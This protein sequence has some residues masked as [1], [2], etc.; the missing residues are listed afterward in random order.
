M[1]NVLNKSIQDQT[2]SNHNYIINGSF[3]VNQRNPKQSIYN[4]GSKDVMDWPTNYE[5]DVA[6]SYKTHSVEFNGDNC[7]YREG[8]YPHAFNTAIIRFIPKNVSKGYQILWKSAGSAAGWWY[9]IN[10]VGKMEFGCRDEDNQKIAHNFEMD[11]QDNHVYEVAIADSN[12]TLVDRTN[13]TYEFLRA[14][15]GVKQEALG[16]DYE[17]IGGSTTANNGYNPVFGTQEFTGFVG[18]IISIEV[19]L[20]GT[21]HYQGDA[22]AYRSYAACDRFY[23]SYTH[24]NSHSYVYQNNGTY[25]DYP[26][27]DQFY[28]IITDYED[29]EDYNRDERY[30]SI[31]QNIENVTRFAG[32]TLTFSMLVHSIKG[33]PL[34]L[35][36]YS[37]QENSDESYITERTF[38]EIEAQNGFQKVSYTFTVPNDVAE[39][40]ENPNNTYLQLVLTAETREDVWDIANLKLEEGRRATPFIE[41]RVKEEY[42]CFRYFYS[43][44]GGDTA[45]DDNYAHFCFGAMESSANSIDSQIYLPVKMR[46][47]PTL[48]VSSLNHISLDSLE[49]DVNPN[50]DVG[51]ITGIE[52]IG[53]GE[54]RDRFGIIWQLNPNGDFTGGVKGFMT[55][56]SAD[57]PTLDYSH[58]VFLDAEID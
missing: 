9:A 47:P 38:S 17:S 21:H 36:M 19:S 43:I 31:G 54:F 24:M 1:T 41:D 4:F 18:E 25:P 26:Y 57:R 6:P 14:G 23:D 34:K 29:M 50:T 44:S 33:E 27:I 58:Y 45:S 28:R 48:S 56:T 3:C 30:F 22:N 53:Q 39:Y 42:D 49:Q 15:N 51:D 37:N 16:S 52:D 20:N 40:I 8:I 10:S 2:E 32:K 7:L 11:I 46:K 13:G 12:S 5:G 55:L 35:S